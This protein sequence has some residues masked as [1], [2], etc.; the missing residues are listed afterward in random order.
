VLDGYPRTLEQSKAIDSAADLDYVF[1]IN[2]RDEVIIERISGRRV[3][4]NGHTWHLKYSP[5][6]AEGICDTCSEPLFQRDDDKE[7]VVRVRLVTYHKNTQPIID[8][9]EKEAVLI[10]I[11]GEQH[12]EQVFQ[13]AV[14]YLVYDL[15]NKALA[16]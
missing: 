15:R 9:Y 10:K 1:L 16:K 6:K 11:N 3:C 8:F 2:V 7:E 4:K 13:E 12:I 14:R 5:T